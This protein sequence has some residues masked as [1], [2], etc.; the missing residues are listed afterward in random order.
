MTP[1]AQERL[2]R[3]RR[4]E[5]RERIAHALGVNVAD[6]VLMGRE[7]DF[8]R[9]QAETPPPVELPPVVVPARKD[10]CLVSKPQ[11]AELLD[12]SASFVNRLIRQGRLEVGYCP[13][14]LDVVVNAETLTWKTREDDQAS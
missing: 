14:C 12:C 11:A 4:R 13:S 5:H 8:A 10:L 1:T 2:E 6:L 9:Q 3:R 7:A